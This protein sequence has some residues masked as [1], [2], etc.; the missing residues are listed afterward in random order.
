[1]D[2]MIA[3]AT[4]RIAACVALLVGMAAQAQEMVTDAAP[5]RRPALFV[6]PDAP[7]A[8]LEQHG[9]RRYVVTLTVDQ[10]GK[11]AGIPGLEPDD[12]EFRKNLEEAAKFWVFY[13]QVDPVACRTVPSQAR[14]ELE[15]EK[16][17]PAPRMWLSFDPMQAL[18]RNAAVDL[19][20]KPPT[21]NYPDE[22]LRNGV[23]GKVYVLLQV[24]SDGSVSD[25][26]LLIGLPPSQNFVRKSLAAAREA[27]F[28][29]ATAATRC[30]ALEYRFLIK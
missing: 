10:H 1:M 9:S 11:V 22:E 28:Q 17:D 2:H 23:Q 15:F 29:P 13:P 24:A 19:V 16:G 27:R 20:K 18:I 30:T 12:A 3:G 8:L 14:I 25:S 4:A 26:R 6:M 21:F 7:R 5:F